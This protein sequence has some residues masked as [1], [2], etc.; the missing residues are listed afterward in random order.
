MNRHKK[1]ILF[2]TLGFAAAHLIFSI[3]L[4]FITSSLYDNRMINVRHL[5]FNKDLQASLIAP[6]IIDNTTNSEQQKL[7]LAGSSFSWGYPFPKAK[8]LSSHLQN[9]LPDQKVINMSVIGD[10]PV[11]T[12]GNLCLVEKLG[13]HVDTIIVEANIANFSSITT[14]LTSSPPR[15]TDYGN[16]AY[17]D[18]ILPYSYFFLSNPF[19]LAHFGIIHD[20]FDYQRKNDVKFR[21]RKVNNGYFNTPDLAQESYEA[22][23]SVLIPL[24]ETSK[25]IANRVIFFFT[26]V[27][28]HGVSLSQYKINDIQSQIDSLLTICKKVGD[29]ECL[30]TQYDLDE[31]MFM[32]LTHLNM[33]G[34]EYFAQYLSNVINSRPSIPP[35]TLSSANLPPN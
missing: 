27:N 31:T 26:P 5:D 34:H 28:A 6:F 13:I 9:N 7:L 21:F 19:G 25:R 4:S 8:T 24:F 18:R 11:G 12:L 20:E 35:Y 22:K 1:F 32:N 33:K 17:I 30:E 10:S 14:M 29:I 2:T 15:C 3:T 16:W 23:K